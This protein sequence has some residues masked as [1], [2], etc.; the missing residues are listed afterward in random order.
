MDVSDLTSGTF[1][2]V[3]YDDKKEKVGSIKFVKISD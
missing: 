1:A 2:L 3:I